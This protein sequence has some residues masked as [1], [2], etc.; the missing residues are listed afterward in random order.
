MTR[1]VGLLVFGI[2]LV[3]L[4]DTA[5]AQSAQTVARGARLWSATC[6]RCHNRRA[7]IERTDAQWDVIVSHMRTRA[8]LT[9][10]EADAIARFL[11]ESNRRAQPDTA[12]QA[13]RG[14]PD[15]TQDIGGGRDAPAHQRPPRTY[16]K[17]LI[18]VGPSVLGPIVLGDFLEPPH[19][20]REVEGR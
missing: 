11:K 4:P 7:T 12:T 2:T 20:P 14:R 6:N 3:T 8:N 9:R 16:P 13:T 17:D 10:S 1:Y 19:R 15:A 18:G 5:V